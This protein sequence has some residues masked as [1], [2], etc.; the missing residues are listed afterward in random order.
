MLDIIIFFS[1]SKREMNALLP[2]PIK[3]PRAIMAANNGKVS[4]SAV[5]MAVFPSVPMKKAFKM[6][7]M[8]LID[9]PS[10]IGTAK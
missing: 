8:T 10:I 4:A 3:L 1:P 2:M 9:I 5:N 7:Y 6:E